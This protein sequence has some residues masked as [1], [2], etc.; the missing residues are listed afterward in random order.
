[1]LPRRWTAALAFLTPFGTRALRRSV[2]RPVVDGVWLTKMTGPSR[3]ARRLGAGLC[4]SEQT[5]HYMQLT[6]EEEEVLREVLLHSLSELEVEIL[7]T[8]HSA[9][10]DQLKQRRRLLQR[11]S[12]RLP[13]PVEPV[14][15]I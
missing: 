7:H 2:P 6:A 11:I 13:G 3:R 8:D 4:Q 1:M 15:W 10:R 14:P 12:E 5:M 9:F